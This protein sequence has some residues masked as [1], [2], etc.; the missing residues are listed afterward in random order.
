[1]SVDKP[2]DQTSR[3]L[4]ARNPDRYRVA[5]GIA[6]ELNAGFNNRRAAKLFSALTRHDVLPIAVTVGTVGALGAVVG[7]AKALR[8]ARRMKPHAI[9]EPPTHGD[10]PARQL[11]VIREAAIRITHNQV[12]A[13]SRTTILEPED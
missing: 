6:R 8:L 5:L 13:L 2:V 9:E 1:M 11:M 4:V 3:A 10:V 7:I 12:V